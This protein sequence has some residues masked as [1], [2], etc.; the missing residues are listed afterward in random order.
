MPR[1]SRPLVSIVTPSFNQG[2]FIERAL[3]G[4]LAQDYPHVEYL[5]V[6]GLSADE[7]AA[8]LDRWR[9]AIDVVLRE[10]DAGQADGLQKGFDRAR[11]EILAYLNADD[12]YAGP[13]VVSR[14]VAYFERHP[15]VDVVFGR[16]VVVDEEGRFVSRWPFVRFD[17]ATLRRVDFIPQECCFWRRSVWERAG[18]YVDRGLDFAID[19]DL[20]LRFLACGGR[21]LAVGDTFGLFR[22][23]GGQKSSARWHEL[24]WPEVQRLHERHGVRVAEHEMESAFLRHTFGSGLGGRLRRAWHALGDRRVRQ[25]ARGRPLDAWVFGPGEAATSRRRLSA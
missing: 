10:R 24:G 22:E 23:H 21:F 1:G 5:V 3:R 4:V 18:G 13:G 20:W 12:C 17:A 9:G 14:A 15:G 6:D 8:V 16:R 7:T 2:R 25:A 11:G 19:Y